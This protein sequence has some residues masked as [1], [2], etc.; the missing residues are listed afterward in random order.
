MNP[1]VIAL[2]RRIRALFVSRNLDAPMFRDMDGG[3]IRKFAR[4]IGVIT[5]KRRSHSN[6]NRNKCSRER[7][8]IRRA[9][10][11]EAEANA[12]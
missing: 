1:S 12:G 3:E 8:A 5:A 4:R 2:K 6:K 11:R 10:M 9:A 7:K